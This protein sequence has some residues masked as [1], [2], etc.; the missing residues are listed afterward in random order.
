VARMTLL[1]GLGMGGVSFV[2]ST[3]A[4]TVLAWLLI[5]VINLRSF[6]WTIFYHPAIEPY[7]I[8]A[9]TAIVASLGAAAYPIWKVCRTY[10]QMQIRE[11]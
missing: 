2:L 11:E 6:N 7:L 4:G 10:P 8:T 3:V 1:E 9:A 5:R